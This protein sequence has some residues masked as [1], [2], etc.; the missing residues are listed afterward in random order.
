MKKLLRLSGIIAVTSIVLVSCKKQDA[1][2]PKEDAVSADVKAMVKAAGFNENR[3][4]V[5]TGGYLIEGDI[6]MTPAELSGMAGN[7]GPELVIAD[8]EH[9]RTTN[10]VS[11][12]G[13]RTITVSLNTTQANFVAAT[14]E[15]ISRYNA[16]PL[17]L[18]FQRVSGTSANI[19]IVT[20]YQVSNVLGSAG[21][22]SGGNPY[23]TIQMNTYW[24]TPSVAVNPL[25]TTIAHEMGHC[26]GFRHTDYMNRS[27]SC[28]G[29]ASN[30]GSAG[31]GAIY[32]PGTPTGGSAGSWM[33][34]CGSTSTNR[35]FTSAD[36]T[37]LNYVY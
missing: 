11:H 14:D 37:A 35:P 24:Y 5:T 30:E 13:T 1:A 36:Q 26:I 16:L 6:F 23:N 19:N 3:I 25:A 15:A 2:V 27:Y 20:F 32:I 4:E 10:L 22:P 31:I 17:T 18:K 9:Y 34:A 12:S 21:F 29:A 7:N 28:G 8:D 33:L